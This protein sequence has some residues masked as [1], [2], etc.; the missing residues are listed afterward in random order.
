MFNYC[1]LEFSSLGL[2]GP[3]LRSAMH[4]TVEPTIGRFSREQRDYM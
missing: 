3:G 2:K 1:L 4:V